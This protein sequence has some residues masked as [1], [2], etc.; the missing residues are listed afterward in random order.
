MKMM[1]MSRKNV[2]IIVAVAVAWM[3]RKQIEKAIRKQ[4]KK[5]EYCS[6]CG[7]LSK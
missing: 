1:N 3:Y 6:K 7:F 2:A 5:E 4:M